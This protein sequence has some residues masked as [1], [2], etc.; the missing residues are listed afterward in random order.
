MNPFKSDVVGSLLRPPYL[1]EARAAPTPATRAADFKRVE[2]RAVDEAVAL[3]EAAG[4]D[5][6]TDG[7]MRRYAFFGHLVD[8]LEGFDK[9]AGWAITFRDDEGH[10]AALAAAGRRRE[11]PL[12]PADVR[13][14]VHLPARPH[15]AA[16]QGHAAQRAAGGGLLRSREVARR[17]RD[18]RRLSRRPRGLHPPRDRGA[19]APRLRVHPDRRAAVRGAARRERSARATASAA[20]IR[21]GCSTPAS[22]S[23]TRSSTG[24]PGVTFGIHICR[25]NH[26][27]M[28]YASGGYDRIAE[29][30]FRAPAS[31]ASCSS[32]T[33]SARERSSRCATCPTTASSCWAW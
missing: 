19:G 26:K 10:K 22:S 25:G 12:A 28:F 6:V 18:P 27:S 14:G 15:D 20:A 17:L 30:V 8:A 23:T 9:P 16:G 29:Q 11:A 2:D 4:L 1:K 7:E 3:Q 24:H 21:T 31:I 33:M 5:V 13:R 32:T